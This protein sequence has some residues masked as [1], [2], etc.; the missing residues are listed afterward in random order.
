[1][2]ATSLVHAGFGVSVISLRKPG[3]AP[4]AVIDGV[5]VY[6]YENGVPACA[7]SWWGW[8]RVAR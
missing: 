4:H 7:L 5:S 8:C 6:R 1:M 2:E 3:D